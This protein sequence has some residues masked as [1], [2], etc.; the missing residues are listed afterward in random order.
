MSKICDLI[1]EVANETGKDIDKIT[2]ADIDKYRAIKREL[3]F[4]K[5][6]PEVDRIE[7]NR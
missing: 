5:K 3:D 1:I 6:G 7:P 4:K 2:D